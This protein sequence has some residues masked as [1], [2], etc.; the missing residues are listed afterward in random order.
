MLAL[1]IR[2]F[3][4]SF[5]LSVSVKPIMLNAQKAITILKV[6]HP[7]SYMNTIPGDRMPYQGSLT[8]EEGSVRLTSFSN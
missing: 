3:L 6:I 7:R 8:E 2:L 4:L 1:N 5:M